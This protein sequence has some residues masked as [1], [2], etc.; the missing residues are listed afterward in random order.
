MLHFYYLAIGYISDFTIYSS[1]STGLLFL[2]HTMLILALGP[3]YLFFF[4]PES[5]LLLI[6]LLSHFILISFQI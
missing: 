4:L 1:L 2:K 3:L 6:R 5:V